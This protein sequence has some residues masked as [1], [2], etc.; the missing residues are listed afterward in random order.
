[1]TQNKS[2][3]SRDEILARLKNASRE[4]YGLP[5]VP[6]YTIPGDPVENF[7]SKLKSFDGKSV[8]VPDRAAA[9]DWLRKNISTD[10]KVLFSAIPEYTGNFTMDDVTDPRNAHKIDICIGEGVMGVGEMG[11]IW[12]TDKSVGKAACALMSTDLYLLLDRTSI[13]DGMHTA[14]SRLNIAAAPYG[15]FFTG[16]SATADIEAVHV[17]GAQGEISLTA[18]I[19]G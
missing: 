1:M 5:D 9:I 15:S 10:G 12:V 14:Y 18:I 13:V 6:M 17:T 2:A 11:A 7:M 4:G 3:S 16:P 8:V 19:Y